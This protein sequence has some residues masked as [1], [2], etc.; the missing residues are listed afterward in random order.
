MHGEQAAAG[1]FRDFD[2]IAHGMED[3]VAAEA[4]P[5]I[6]EVNRKLC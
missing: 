6:G 4:F 1:E 5:L 3:K 2:G